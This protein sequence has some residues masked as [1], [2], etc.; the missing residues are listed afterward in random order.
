MPSMRPASACDS[1]WPKMERNSPTVVNVP[2]AHAAPAPSRTNCV[3]T[4][5]CSKLNA[6]THALSAKMTNQR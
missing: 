6:M 4:V 2:A 1:S 5:P 3:K